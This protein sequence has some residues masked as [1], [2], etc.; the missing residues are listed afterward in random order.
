MVDNGTVT[1]K[2]DREVHE[3][4]ARETRKRKGMT[5]QGVADEVIRTGLKVKR[6]AI[7]GE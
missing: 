3:A 2:I 1:I 7:E 6:I 5:L 4:L